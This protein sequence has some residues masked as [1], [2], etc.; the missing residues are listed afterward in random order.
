MSLISAAVFSIAI[1]PWSATLPAPEIIAGHEVRR[2]SLFLFDV[3]RMGVLDREDAV[4][5]LEEAADLAE[6]APVFATVPPPAPTSALEDAPV[7]RPTAPQ[8]DVAGLDA[9]VDDGAPAEPYQEADVEEPAADP[10]AEPIPEE[11]WP[12]AQVTLCEPCKGSGRKGKKRCAF[13]DGR[14]VRLVVGNILID[15]HPP[16][17][18][19]GRLAG[20]YALSDFLREMPDTA[21]PGAL[22]LL[23]VVLRGADAD[24]SVRARAQWGQALKRRAEQ[25]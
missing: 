6:W 24:T 18:E 11:D 21:L 8:D 22:E 25:T 9:A 7:E 1:F 10:S 13:C 20:A 4:R 19:E 3:D 5:R 14:V 23:E 15:R 12:A 16:S 17:T 2:I